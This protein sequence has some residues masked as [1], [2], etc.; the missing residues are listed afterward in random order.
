MAKASNNK[1]Q[2]QAKIAELHSAAIAHYQAGRLPDAESACRE[3]LKLTPMHGEALHLYGI[4][5]GQ[6]GKFSEAIES[7]QKALLIK[8][9]DAE[10]LSNLGKALRRMRRLAEAIECL[11][12]A[13]R[14]KPGLPDTLYNLGL[15]FQDQGEHDRASAQFAEV[16]R[17]R[18]SYPVL[19][20]NL[21][22]RL[23]EQGKLDDAID[24]FTDA[25]RL[26][27]DFLEAHYHVAVLFAMRNRV[28]EAHDHLARYLAGDPDDKMG[29]R[30]VLA[31]L[32]LGPLPDRASNAHVNRMYE[33]R[34]DSYDQWNTYYAH[35]LIARTLTR[36]LPNSGA[37]D[38]LDAGCG[39][40]LTGA[41]I[42]EAARQLD[43]IDLSSAMLEKA[44]QKGVYTNLYQDEFVAFMVNH[45]ASY[46]VVV[47]AG[48]L[49]HVGELTSVFDATATT[50]R[51]E[52][53]FVFTL[54]L[55]E[56]EREGHEVMV[57]PL[58]GYCEGGCYLHGR[59]YVRRVARDT[60]FAVVSVETDVHERSKGDEKPGL[61]VALRRN[62]GLV[63][64]SDL[65]S[66]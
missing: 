64:Q 59:D 54:L 55:N 31:R 29:A 51:D 16:L 39:T 63:M 10:I 5:T 19:F 43:G 44:K 57:A 65:P 9:K 53:L 30:M 36:L 61:V 46:D 4:I 7:L 8:P 40:G 33:L 48:A 15:A 37:F 11:E 52:G 13:L 1:P 25:L 2:I 50:L 24:R 22:I 42:R 41:L 12:H 49:I 17:V 45:P 3:I 32:G 14:I 28:Q 6:S 18:P 27:P 38:I 23:Q 58:G 56:D 47:S 66:I 34:A 21:A 20:F 60:G 35:E 26:R 62:P